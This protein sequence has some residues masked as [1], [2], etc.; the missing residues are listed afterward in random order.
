MQHN[1]FN[2]SGFGNQPNNLDMISLRIDT[3]LQQ[4]HDWNGR[5]V[6][7]HRVVPLSKWTRLRWNTSWCLF[8]WTLKHLRLKRCDWKE[9]NEAHLL[10]VDVYRHDEEK[11]IAHWGIPCEDNHPAWEP[12]RGWFTNP[13]NQS[14]AWKQREII[15]QR[16]PASSRFALSFL[17]RGASMQKSIIH[18]RLVEPT[19]R[20]AQTRNKKG[21]TLGDKWTRA[22]L[23]QSTE[24]MRRIYTRRSQ[25]PP[26][27]PNQ[28]QAPTWGNKWMKVKILG[29]EVGR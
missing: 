6:G 12:L 1:P 3:T 25:N 7:R 5:K 9:C 19:K 16:P 20:Q 15:L 2:Q 28:S 10:V 21:D 26:S 27:Q 23:S 4:L 17:Q 18:G 11:V 8:I 22:V 24:T 29:K 14:V 13:Q